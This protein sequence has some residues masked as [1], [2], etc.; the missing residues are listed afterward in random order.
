MH[1]V[2]VRIKKELYEKYQIYLVK[3]DIK[4]KADLTSHINSQVL[5]YQMPCDYSKEYSNMEYSKLNF[6]VENN[7]YKNYKITLIENNTTPTADIIR[8]IMVAV[9]K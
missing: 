4:M 7:L 9:E 5:N 1:R 8:H 6:E 2:T 3:N